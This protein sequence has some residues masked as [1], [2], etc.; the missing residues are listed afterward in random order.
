MINNLSRLVECIAKLA[1]LMRIAATTMFFRT[2]NFSCKSSASIISRIVYT[3]ID[4][5]CICIFVYLVARCR[6][7]TFWMAAWVLGC[8]VKAFWKART[9][10]GRLAAWFP[11]KG[12]S[13]C[14]KLMLIFCELE[15]TSL[16][17]P[18]IKLASIYCARQMLTRSVW[19]CKYLFVI[20]SFWFAQQQKRW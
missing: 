13:I 14:E 12:V 10:Y 8:I 9:V 5:C 19:I 15:L 18:V 11:V 4:M 7:W 1:H 6:R 17:R 16:K 2:Q 20:Y 3:R